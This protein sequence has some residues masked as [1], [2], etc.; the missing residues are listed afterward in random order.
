MTV[1]EDPSFTRVE[2]SSS[3]V[4]A[5][6]ALPESSVPEDVN[7][8]IEDAQSDLRQFQS[9]ARFVIALGQA[10]YLYGSFG[11]TIESC[12]ATV[13]QS[14]GYTGLFRVTQSEIMANMQMT[15]DS[16]PVFYMVRATKSMN[17]NKLGLLAVVAQNG[18]DN[19]L[20]AEEGMEKLKQVD[21]AEDPFGIFPSMLSYIM[22]G[23]G[24]AMVLG[25]SWWDVWT[26]A[27]AGFINFAILTIATKTSHGNDWWVNPLCSFLIAVFAS[28][29]KTSIR[30]NLNLTIVTLSGVAIQLPG[31]GAALGLGELVLDRVV[32]GMSH[33]IQALILLLWLVLGGYLGGALVN[34]IRPFETIEDPS[35][36]VPGVWQALFVPLL[37]ISLVIAFQNSF[38]DAAWAVLCQGVAY[39]VSYG[40]TQIATPNVGMFLSGVVYTIFSI[41]WGNHYN[42]SYTLILIPTIVLSVSGTIGFRGILNLV[43]GDTTVGVEQFLQMIVVALLLIAGQIVGSTV[44]KPRGIL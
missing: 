4:P 23:A 2:S 16:L 12:L 11:H 7:V 24:L 15:P 26:G 39:S 9:A 34:A 40:F 18:A 35:E 29:I 6:V 13:L 44:V 22:I 43:E 30:P 32:A 8:D 33:F 1:E 5:A 17:L 42:R 31:F 21:E 41:L 14:F 27:I 3:E 10:A 38:F 20:T 28:S 25:G 36:P 37:A 19:K